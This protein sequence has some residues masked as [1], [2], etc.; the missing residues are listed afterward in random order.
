M[1]EEFSSGEAPGQA[2]FVLR[3]LGFTVLKK[4]D[5]EQQPKTSKDWWQRFGPGDRGS[6]IAACA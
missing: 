5:P 6:S 1:P 4:S 2:N 3:K